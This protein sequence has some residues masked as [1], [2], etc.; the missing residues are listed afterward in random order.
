MRSKVLC[1]APYSNYHPLHGLWEMTVLNGLRVRGA[2]V[3]YYLCDALSHRCDLFRFAPGDQDWSG[4]VEPVRKQRTCK[5]LPMAPS[6]SSP[7]TPR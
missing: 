5:G 2:E 4:G 7:A 6:S 3:A 1:I